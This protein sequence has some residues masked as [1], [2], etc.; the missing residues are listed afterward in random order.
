MHGAR[1]RRGAM[2]VLHELAAVPWVRLPAAVSA[3]ALRTP[4]QV[5]DDARNSSNGLV[6]GTGGGS[7]ESPRSGECSPQNEAAPASECVWWIKWRPDDT[8]RAYAAA[9]TD[10]KTVYVDVHTRE[11]LETVVAFDEF[12]TLLREMPRLIREGSV[13]SAVADPRTNNLALVLER[14][15]DRADEAMNTTQKHHSGKGGGSIRPGTARKVSWMFSA[16]RLDNSAEALR[17]YFIY[18]YMGMSAAFSVITD[19]LLS[20]VEDFAQGGMI[21]S[22]VGNG[23]S[24]ANGAEMRSVNSSMRLAGNKN[25]NLDVVFSREA[26]VKDMLATDSDVRLALSSEAVL[27]PSAPSSSASTRSNALETSLYQLYF[28]NLASIRSRGGQASEVQVQVLAPGSCHEPV[29]LPSRSETNL[30]RIATPSASTGAAPRTRAHE[31][32]ENRS[33]DSIR[34]FTATSGAPPPG[35]QHAQNGEMLRL[36][37]TSGL[38]EL[39]HGQQQNEAPLGRLGSVKAVT[40]GSTYAMQGQDRHQQGLGMAVSSVRPLHT[41][42]GLAGGL[43]TGGGVSGGGATLSQASHTQKRERATHSDLIA[44]DISNSQASFNSVRS[45][46]QRKRKNLT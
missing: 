7:S 35:A 6:R 42:A 21:M 22:G 17:D 1:Q 28:Q 3:S 37:G 19:K 39:H 13:V 46:K 18:P 36:G 29:A 24:D 40:D 8:A 4:R 9:L 11:T 15:D 41:S 2:N 16:A 23:R 38:V 43:G 14:S 5:S 31:A 32:N 26:Y 45:T 34:A 10:L 27:L 33:Q 20:R 25:S 44:I 30:H 12:D